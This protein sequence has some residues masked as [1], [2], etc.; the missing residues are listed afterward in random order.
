MEAWE[1]ALTTFLHFYISTSPP[2]YLLFPQFYISAFRHFYLCTLQHVRIPF[3]HFYFQASSP[4][5][6]WS[7]ETQSNPT[8]NSYGNIT[9][10]RWL[11]TYIVVY[12]VESPVFHAH[13]RFL[14]SPQHPTLDRASSTGTPHGV[15]IKPARKSYIASDYINSV[16]VRRDT[17]TND[18]FG[19]CPII[20][21]PKLHIENMLSNLTESFVLRKNV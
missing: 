16:N 3:Q 11:Y 21:T 17:G 5:S 7:V 20:R 13:T 1:S 10:T 15:L 12:P 4:M 18:H 14:H 2:V 9:D 6:L 8:H 19:K